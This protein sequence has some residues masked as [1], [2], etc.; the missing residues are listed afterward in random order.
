MCWSVHTHAQI[1]IHANMQRNAVAV[2]AYSVN[3]CRGE[4][5]IWESCTLTPYTYK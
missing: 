5:I 3:I 1:H 4:R 2:L